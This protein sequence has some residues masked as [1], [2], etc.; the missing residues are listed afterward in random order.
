[1]LAAK[2]NLSAHTILEGNAVFQEF[3]GALAEQYVLQQFVAEFGTIPYYW[4][5]KSPTCE[6]DFLMELEENIIPLE[7][8]AEQN[9]QAKSLK[10]YCKKFRPSKAVRISMGKYFRQIVADAENNPDGY[11]LI[12]LP[13]F[14]VSQLLQECEK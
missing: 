1:M 6:V 11:A 9:R 5:A 8:K 12:D 3:K 14:A 7:V 2:S 13:L 4:A 10:F